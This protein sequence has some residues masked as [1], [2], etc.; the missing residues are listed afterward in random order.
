[1]LDVEFIAM[2]FVSKTS[3]LNQYFSLENE[4]CVILR[5]EYDNPGL[6]R[7]SLLLPPRNDTRG[8]SSAKPTNSVENAMGT[9]EKAGLPSSQ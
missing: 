4:L 5:F 3:N 2:T 9:Q 7:Q 8:V 1:M 6:P